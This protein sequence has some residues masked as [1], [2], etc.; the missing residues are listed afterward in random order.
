MMGASK[1]FITPVSPKDIPTYYEKV[2]RPVCLMDIGNRL[3]TAARADEPD[4]VFAV[5]TMVDDCTDAEVLPKP[6]W[7]ERKLAYL[8][9]LPS[10]HRDSLL[11]SMADKLHNSSSIL[12]DL[13]RHGPTV[14]DR[15]SAGPDDTVWYYQALVE[16]F[17]SRQL[18]GDAL[19]LLQ[20]LDDVV[21][22]LHKATE[23][24]RA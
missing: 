2:L 16:A 7:R 9:H 17:A 12:R 14:F 15:F 22:Q 11:V 23:L 19:A 13:K 20:E 3:L 1:N 4:E 21:R 8:A 5:T 18:E 6:P 10:A 24:A